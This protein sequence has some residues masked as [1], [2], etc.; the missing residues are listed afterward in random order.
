MRRYGVREDQWE[1]IKDRL[2][3]R[4]GSRGVTAGETRLCVE[5]VFYR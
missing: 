3:G 2:P 1:R 4:A 5:A